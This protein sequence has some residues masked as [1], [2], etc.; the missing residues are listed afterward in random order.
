MNAPDPVPQPPPAPIPWY[1]SPVLVGILTAV[2]AQ[3]IARVQSYWHIN[4]AVFGI[5]ASDLANW[6]L[7]A[8]SAAAVAWAARSRIKSTAAPVTF[9]KPP[10]PPPAA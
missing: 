7:D 1:K 5:D 10:A 6:I 3:I 4:L 9:K 8:V 2:S